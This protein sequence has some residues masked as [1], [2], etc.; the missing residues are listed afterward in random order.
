[1]P[2]RAVWHASEII[3]GD[4]VRGGSVGLGE[5]VRPWPWREFQNVQN[6]LKGVTI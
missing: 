6:F 1:M 2:Y 4:S 5:I 3:T